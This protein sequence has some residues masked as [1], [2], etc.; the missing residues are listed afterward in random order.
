LNKIAK[1]SFF[2]FTATPMNCVLKCLNISIVAILVTVITINNITII[3]TDIT[4]VTIITPLS[5]IAII[6]INAMTT[7]IIGVITY[8][9]YVMISDDTDDCFGDSIDTDNSNY[10]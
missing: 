5:I 3:I 9:C 8:Q 1:K 10:R 4:V 7:T 2:S 6:A